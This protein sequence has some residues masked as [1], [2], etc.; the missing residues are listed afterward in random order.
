MHEAVI[1]GYG[2]AGAQAAIYLL[3]GGI[4]P[5]IIGRDGGALASAERIDNFFGRGDHP[6][7]LDLI[8]AGLGQIRELGGEITPGEVVSIAFGDGFTVKTTEG[9][10]ETKTIL[11][12]VGRQRKK[13]SIAGVEAYEERGV[14]YCAVCDGFFYRGKSVAVLGEGKYALSE[15]EELAN[16]ASSV[17]IY[18]NGR[19]AGFLSP[20]GIMIDTRPIL[21]IEGTERVEG[22]RFEDGAVDTDGLF[23]AEGSASGLDFARKLGLE[24]KDGDIVTNGSQMTNIPGIFAAGDCTGGVLQVVV[25]AGEGA[26]AGLAMMEFIRKNR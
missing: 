11:M 16:H 21:G 18:T 25:A 9:E 22:L 26:C 23:V 5:L 4:K 2:P 8:E 10:Y 14:S 7:G 13:P 3:R 19:E 12:A 15:A 1:L 17:T 24:V 6:S 20:D